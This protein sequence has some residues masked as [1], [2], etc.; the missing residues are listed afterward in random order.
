VEE[1]AN[2]RSADLSSARGEMKCL[3]SIFLERYPVT[4]TSDVLQIGCQKHKVEKWWKF[5]DSE[6]IEMDGDYALEWWNKYKAI[7]K[8]IIELS[9]ALPTK[10]I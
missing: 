3:K 4:Y 10:E 7:I 1:R 8:S 5:K 9:P 2:L 6:I